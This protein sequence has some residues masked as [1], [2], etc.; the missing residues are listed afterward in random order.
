MAGAVHSTANKDSSSLTTQTFS[1]YH[2][3][4]TILQ[5]TPNGVLVVGLDHRV[6]HANP[7]AGLFRGEPYGNLVGGTVREF[8][9]EKNAALF[10]RIEQQF[11]AENQENGWKISQEIDF[12]LDDQRR[13]LVGVVV[14]PPAL[15]DYYLLYLIDITQQ[16]MLESRLRRRNAFFHNLIDSSVD[17]II[18]S[19]MKGH[20]V[21]FNSGAHALLGYDEKDTMTLHVTKL[22]NEGVAYELIKRMRS[23]DFGGKG[24]LSAPTNDR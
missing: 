13:N 23:D 1:S 17:G 14:Y 6:L 4:N 24:K 2:F 16:K 21:L 10:D 22:Y 8:L 20:I 9:G 3:L 19:D 11:Q 5:E 7:A 12:S 18:A 15:S